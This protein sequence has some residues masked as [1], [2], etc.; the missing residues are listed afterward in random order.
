M[1]SRLLCLL[2]IFA[3]TVS[4][5]KDLRILWWNVQGFSNDKGLVQQKLAEVGS[6]YDVI[7]LGESKPE[8]VKD[9]LKTSLSVFTH[10]ESLDYPD[11]AG[12]AISIL[13][14][15]LFHKNHDLNLDWGEAGEKANWLKHYANP[16][17]N[18]R[19]RLSVFEVNVDG[20]IF[21]L[22]PVHFV[23]PWPIMI[24]KDGYFKTALNIYGG[25]ASPLLYQ[26]ETT[27]SFLK[28]NH[29]LDSNS[30]FVLLGDFN[31]PSDPMPGYVIQ[32]ISEYMD[33][34]M[35]DGSPSF[36]SPSLKIDHAFGNGGV[37]CW[38]DQVLPYE[39]SDHYPI[40]VL[41]SL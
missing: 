32:K 38:D 14:K 40:E 13:S 17:Y 1:F 4:L 5:A 2:F 8:I 11:N 7:L 19:R 35:L 12:V 24:A 18:P 25:G 27:L 9:L 15:F 31:A 3:P 22:A 28:Q 36:K 26:V 6:D 29:F 39:G 16:P 20:D 37:E 41:L 34:L 30:A 33:D 10:S 23:N 21:N